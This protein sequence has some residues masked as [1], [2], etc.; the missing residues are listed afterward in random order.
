MVKEKIKPKFHTDRQVDALKPINGKQTD[1]SHSKFPGFFLRVGATKKTWIVRYYI[2]GKLKTYSLPIPYPE[3][4]LEQATIEYQRIRS[5]ANKGH[6]PLKKRVEKRAAPT[7]ADVM[8]YYYQEQ[9][10]LPSGKKEAQRATEKDINPLLGHLKAADLKRQHIK[11]LHKLIVER[12]APV[13]A[14][15][16]I[17]LMQ[18]AFIY[19]FEEEIITTNPFPALKKIKAAEYERKRVLKEEEIR[20]LWPAMDQLSD[21]MRDIH[22]LLL[23]LGQRTND[24]CAMGVDEIDFENKYWIVPGRD[25][26]PRAKNREENA[27][28]LAPLAWE[29]I[30][31]RYLAAKANKNK[32]IFPSA[33]N[34]TRAGYEDTGHTKSTKK[35]R[36][37]LIKITGIE[38]W[39]GHDLRRT[40]RTLLSGLNVPP[41]IAE[42]V[43]GHV[44]GG[45]EGIYDQYPYIKEKGDAL[46]KLDRLIR[47]IVGMD[48]KTAKVVHLRRANG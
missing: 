28:P 5:E 20:L 24:V 46:L 8:E 29:I 36:L 21:N 17:S 1:Y 39:T 14:N 19:A 18:R 10:L 13:Q 9:E 34:T 25:T 45:V 11:E 2:D 44:Q 4:S 15:R 23:L 41:H 12:G 40:L 27:L 47:Q 22:R 48:V 31:P 32:W 3:C 6:D 38:D 37:Q 7:I 26:R 30:E 43:L 33:Y 16:T 42:R 35:A